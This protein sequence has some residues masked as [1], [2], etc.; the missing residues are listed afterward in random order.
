MKSNAERERTALR[1]LDTRALFDLA[2]EGESLARRLAVAM[3]RVTPAMTAA[4]EW[5]TARA[6]AAEIKLLN[7]GNGRIASRS[8][9]VVR[10]LKRATPITDAPAFISQHA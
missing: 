3:A 8:L 9:E 1:T 7:F 2:S 4:P 10:A 5:K 6:V